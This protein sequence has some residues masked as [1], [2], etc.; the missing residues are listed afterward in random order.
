MVVVGVVT[1]VDFVVVVGVLGV[2]VLLV[3]FVVV[4]GISN[5]D[6]DVPASNVGHIHVLLKLTFVIIN[7]TLLYISSD[8]YFTHIKHLFYTSLGIANIYCNEEYYR[9]LTY[10]IKLEKVTIALHCNLRPPNVAPFVLGFNYEAH[11][12]PAYQVSTQSGKAQLS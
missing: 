6:V 9:V 8:V 7:M 3:V 12:A 1:V 2:V 4:V 10:D 11:N 5:L